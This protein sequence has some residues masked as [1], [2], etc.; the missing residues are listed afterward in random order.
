VWQ[1]PR[2]GGALLKRVTEPI[3]IATLAV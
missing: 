1:A 3:R 2:T